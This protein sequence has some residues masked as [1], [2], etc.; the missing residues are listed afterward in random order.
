MIVDAMAVADQF[1]DAQ[2]DEMKEAFNMF[3]RNKDGNIP[4]L[5]LEAIF[6][7]LGIHTTEAELKVRF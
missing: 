1:T 6:K 5:Q 7:M 3:D 2:I 4:I